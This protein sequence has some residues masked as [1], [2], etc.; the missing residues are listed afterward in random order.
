M[1][2][3]SLYVLGALYVYL[4]LFCTLEVYHRLGYGVYVIPLVSCLKLGTRKT[5]NHASFFYLI[6]GFLIPKSDLKLSFE[7]K[8]R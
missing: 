3:P 4:L 2:I 1:Y 7:S 8:A 6:C 5:C